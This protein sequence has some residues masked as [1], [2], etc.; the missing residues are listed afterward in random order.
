MLKKKKKLKKKK[1]KTAMFIPAEI[2]LFIQIVFTFFSPF[3]FT[4]SQVIKTKG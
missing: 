2:L 1:N 3:H 4:V